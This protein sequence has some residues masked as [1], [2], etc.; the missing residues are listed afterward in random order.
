M[1]PATYW[2]GTHNGLNFKIVH[3]GKGESYCAGGQGVWNYYI[4]INEK[5]TNRFPELWLEPKVIDPGTSRSFVLYD[6]Y[7]TFIASAD[8]HGGVTYYAKHGEV[9]GPRT[10]EFGC[11]YNHLYDSHCVHTLESVL[12]DCKRTIDE[13]VPMLGMEAAL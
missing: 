9:S 11:D 3:W 10:V 1:K 13:I 5:Q 6:Y 8:W 2:T 4:Y 7:K 12:S